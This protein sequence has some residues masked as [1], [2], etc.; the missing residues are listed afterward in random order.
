[1]TVTSR[2]KPP[3]PWNIHFFRRDESD[4]PVRSVPAIEFLDSIPAKVAAEIDPCGP[5]R[6]CRGAAALVLWR[7]QVGGNA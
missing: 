7:R 3:K 4:D 5:R 6:G 2:R 1:M